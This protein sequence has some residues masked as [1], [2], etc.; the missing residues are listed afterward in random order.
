MS[1]PANP[2]TYGGSVDTKQFIGRTHEINRV[3]DQLTN[4]A[5]GS[6]AIIGE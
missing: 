1:K 4:Q 5:R 6:V 3:F 2:F